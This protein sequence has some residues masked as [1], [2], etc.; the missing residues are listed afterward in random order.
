MPDEEIEANIITIISSLCQQRNPALGPFINRAALMTL[1][2]KTFYSINI[3]EW[4]PVPTEVEI[5]KVSFKNFIFTQEVEDPNTVMT[6][7]IKK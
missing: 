6:T 5:R 4:L 7:L 1:P 3:N 2:G